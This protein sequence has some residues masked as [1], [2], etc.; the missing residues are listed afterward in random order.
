MNPLFSERQ[1]RRLNPVFGPPSTEESAAAAAI[2]FREFFTGG[3]APMEPSLL[4]YQQGKELE[5]GMTL[6][7]G[8]LPLTVDAQTGRPM[9]AMPKLLDALLSGTPSAV[10]SRL[11]PVAA[12]AGEMVSGTGPVKLFHGSPKAD[13][14]ELRPSERG[15]LGPGTYLTPNEGVAKRYAGP[16]GKIYGKVVEED[17]YF[18]GMRSAVDDK[19]NPYQTWRDQT[20]R[21]VDAAEPENKAAVSALMEKMSYDD[22]YPFYARL[23]GMLG[24]DEKAQALISKAGY[25]G[26]T[27]FVDGPEWVNFGGLGGLGG[28]P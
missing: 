21:L 14:T 23:K 17:D 15:P 27:G 28:V 20:R 24:S 13:L 26:L 4:E 18:Q 19:A 16:E 22:G 9:L 7:P 8:F 3:P 5:P 1:R 11:A 12:K 25:K 2:P 10:G 6:R